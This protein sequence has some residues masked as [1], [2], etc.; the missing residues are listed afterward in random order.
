MKYLMLYMIG[1]AA[2]SFLVQSILC[3]KVKRGILRHGVLLLP[4]VSLAMG[5]YLL[6]TQCGDV[7][8]GLG[9]IVAVLWFI[10]GCCAGLGYG[11]AWLFFCVTRKGNSRKQEDQ[12]KA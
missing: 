1:P 11:A 8:G 5:V 12:D 9:A 2:V 4:I 7:F 3:R 6:L 10:A